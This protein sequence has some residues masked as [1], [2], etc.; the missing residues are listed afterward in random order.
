MRVLVVT[1]MWPSTER[2]ASGSFVRDQVRALGALPDVELELFAF[3]HG[4]GWRSYLRAARAL[5]RR[6][7]GRR[8]DVVHAHYGLSGWSALAVP[9]P[10]ARVVTYHGTDLHDAAVG[11]LSRALAALVDVPATVSAGLAR[12]PS[13]GLRGAGVSRRVAVLPCGVDLDRFRPLDRREARRGLGLDPERP[14]L[15]FPAAPGRPEK[16]HDRARLLADGLP[17]AELLSLGTVAPEDVP[18][19]VNAA[20]AVVV[21]SARE[22]FGLAALEALACDVPVLSTDVGV[23]PVALR[24]VQGTLCAPFE[25]ELWLAATRPLVEADDPRVAGRARARAFS[26]DRMAER[27]VAAYRDLVGPG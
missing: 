27:V 1:N 20:N 12:E 26:S 4:G 8:F 23:A 25:R 5:R 6:F 13:A 14:Y 24:G 7:A 18:A 3:P 17:G 22:A 2:P 10:S 16:R 11:P 19:L 9:R 15:L 21:T